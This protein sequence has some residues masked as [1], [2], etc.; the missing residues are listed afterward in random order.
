MNIDKLSMTQDEKNVFSEF[1]NLNDTI[2]KLD[3][4]KKKYT[5]D[6][7][8]I[9]EKYNV[10]DGIDY[11]GSTFTVTESTRKTV[12]SAKKDEFIAE[13]SALNKK[14]LLTTSIEVDTEGVYG[15]VQNGMLDKDFVAKYMSITP[16]KTLRC[17]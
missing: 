5:E 4:Q 8:Q 17:D 15:E 7:K 3:K 1:I 16:V 6:I 2:K 9:F 12:K 11:A 14:Y 10:Q 13:L